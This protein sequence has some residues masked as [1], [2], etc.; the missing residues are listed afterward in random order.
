MKG[1]AVSFGLPYLAAIAGAAGYFFRA[2]QRAGG[3]AVPVIAFSVL[4]CLLFLLGAAT[5]EKREAYADVYRKLPSDA[6]LSIL[7][8]LAVAAGCVLAFSG[9][10]RF[11]MMLNVLGI[12]SA[13]G[14]AAA[15]VSRLAGKK[16]QPFFLVLPVLF[17]AVKLFYDFRH[18]TTDPQILDYAFSLFALIGFMLTTYQAAAYCYDHGSRWQME[19]FA[20][21]GVLF[22]AAGAHSGC[23]PAACRRADGGARGHD[24]AAHFAVGAAGGA[25]LRAAGFGG[26][27]CGDA[28]CG[29]DSGC[30]GQ[31]GK[32]R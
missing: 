8:A 32:D 26:T 31:S 21:A 29:F 24:S 22:G 11:S 23:W 18:W 25:A 16:P 2:A 6:A 20:L 28:N 17:Y 14:L 5:L 1:K 3:S 13:A 10:G 4:M 9:A 19:F 30:A 27:G 15:A 7:G 12:V